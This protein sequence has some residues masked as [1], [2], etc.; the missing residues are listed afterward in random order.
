MVSN[1]YHPEDKIALRAPVIMLVLAAIAIPVEWRPLGSAKLDFSIQ[2]SDVVANIAGFVPVGI[3][4]GELGLLRAV[5]VAALLSIFAETGQLVMVHRVPSAIDVVSN[6][7]G[8]I[9]GTIV[10]GHWRIHSPEFRINRSRAMAAAT[11]AFALILGV[12]ATSGDAVNARG[13]TFP[14]TLEAYWKFDESRGR[15]ALDSSGHGLHGRFNNE[16]RRVSGMLAGAVRLDGAE[17]YI[18]FGHSTALRLAG[19]MTISAWINSASFPADD[20]AIVSQFHN[21]FGY[22]LDTTVDRG[23]RMI[24]FKLTNACGDLMARYGAT[25]LA[26]GTWYHVA[27]VYDTEAQTLDVYLNGELDNGFLLG[28]VTRAQHSSRAAVYVGRR[29]DLEGYAFAGSIDDVRIYSSALMKSEIVAD[30]RGGVID[31]LAVQRATGRGVNSGRGAVHPRD[32]DAPCAVMSELEDTKIP[33]AAAML[34]VLVAVACVGLWPSVGSLLCLV[35]SFAAG[36]LLLPAAA[37][38]LPLFNLCMMSL[39]SL[40]GGASVAVSVRR[41]KRS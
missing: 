23:P 10:S 6:V 37:S 33:G 41:Q 24:G 26:A 22:Q 39:V 30:M 8:G 13:T 11:L 34:G 9:L 4:L 40:A 32:P 12:W 17:D 38:T 21:E 1:V 18:D 16:P 7:I 3:V 15:V 14:G 25:P 2:A 5:T 36:L 35:M 27:G 20:A 31:R 28:P 19:S 29:T